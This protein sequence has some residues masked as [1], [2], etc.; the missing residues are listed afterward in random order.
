M[1]ESK[2]A[3]IVMRSRPQ[4]QCKTI[5]TRNESDISNAAMRPAPSLSRPNRSYLASSHR[6]VLASLGWAR[7]H[8][9]RFVARRRPLELL[10]DILDGA[11]TGCRVDGRRVAKVGVDACEQLAVGGFDAFHDNMALG[12]LLAVA[13]GA[14]QLA[15]VVDG[16][17]VDGDG[18]F[19]V[20]LDDFVF[21]A[22]GASA[23][24]CGYTG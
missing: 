1:K 22:G 3:L 10:A 20:V 17:A 24:D 12:A 2:R 4:G 11:S 14:V 7:R 21:G 6:G 8:R 15:E 9:T 23:D 13:A 18:A 5:H 19:A 16:E